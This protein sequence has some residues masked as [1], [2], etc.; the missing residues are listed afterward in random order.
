MER[1]LAF[2]GSDGQALEWLRLVGVPAKASEPD[3]PPAVGEAVGSRAR[4]AARSGVSDVHAPSTPLVPKLQVDV[5]E[6]D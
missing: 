4:T 1:I 2:D 6:L 5:Y 3:F